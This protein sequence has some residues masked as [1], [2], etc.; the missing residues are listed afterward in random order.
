MEV[1]ALNYL[2]HGVVL[3][4]VGGGGVVLGDNDRDMG[5]I[6]SFT[7]LNY[8]HSTHLLYYQLNSFYILSFSL[9]FISVHISLV[10]SL[11]YRNSRKEYLCVGM[12]VCMLEL[13]GLLF[14]RFANKKR[15]LVSP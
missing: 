14:F 2:Y 12:C 7:Q 13:C 10:F 8:A 1:D 3:V 4:V 5:H 9:Y 15:Y 6:F 11:L